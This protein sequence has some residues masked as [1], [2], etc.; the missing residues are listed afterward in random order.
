MCLLQEVN[1]REEE[2]TLTN[3]KPRKREVRRQIDLANGWPKISQMGH[4]KSIFEQR[5]CLA[6]F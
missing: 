4:P 1:T 5:K 3:R 2:G 6:I